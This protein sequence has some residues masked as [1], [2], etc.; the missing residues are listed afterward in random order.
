MQNFLILD[1]V[2]ANVVLVYHDLLTAKISQLTHIYISVSQ[3][4]VFDAGARFN[5]KGGASMR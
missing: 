2:D 3:K 1:V 4:A 5:G